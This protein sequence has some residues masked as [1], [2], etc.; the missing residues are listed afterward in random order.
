MQ[1]KYLL[2][3]V[4][5]YEFMMVLFRFAHADVGSSAKCRSALHA[6]TIISLRS[7]DRASTTSSDLLQNFQPATHNRQ[8]TLIP[9]AL[10]NVILGSSLRR[11]HD[12]SGFHRASSF[13]QCAPAASQLAQAARHPQCGSGRI[14]NARVC[15]TASEGTAVE[16]RSRCGAGN[17]AGFGGHAW[18]FRWR[19]TM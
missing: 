6:R 13:L 16:Y 8:E 1:L 9:V 10:Y 15:I 17:A 11:A 19:R 3:S 14:H 5:F 2:A 7:R 4:A 18:C 12:P